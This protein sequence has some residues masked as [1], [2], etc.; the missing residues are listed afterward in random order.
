MKFIHSKKFETRKDL[1]LTNEMK[2]MVSATAVKIT[3]GLKEYLLASFDS[4][5]IYPEEFYS[6]NS[7]A[8]SKGETNARGV[9][10][11][12][13]KDFKFGYKYPDDSLNLGY[14]E[15]AHAIFIDHFKNNIDDRFSKNYVKWLLHL[16]YRQTIS[17]IAQKHIF[18]KYVS[19]NKHEFF[20]VAVEN[21]FERPEH[22]RE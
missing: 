3:F 14:H 2:L 9:I 5:I 6:R 12:S 8:I 1:T 17:Q 16:K 21:F 7:N 13:W 19:V 4:I 22:F 11:F 10:V 20:A 15:F 18:R